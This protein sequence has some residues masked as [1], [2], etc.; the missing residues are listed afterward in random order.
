MM[1]VWGG[2]LRSLLSALKSQMAAKACSL[3]ELLYIFIPALICKDQVPF[4]LIFY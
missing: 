2:R 1:V 4:S 3:L